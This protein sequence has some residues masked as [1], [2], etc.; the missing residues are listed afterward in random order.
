MRCRICDGRG[1]VYHNH[2]RTPEELRLAQEHFTNGAKP[3]PSV[4]IPRSCSLCEGTGL[5]G[6]APNAPDISSRIDL[7]RKPF[8]KT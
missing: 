8:G 2:K 4:P 3:A 5:E 6:G 7:P 1:W